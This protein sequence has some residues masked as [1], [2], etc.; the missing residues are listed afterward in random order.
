VEELDVEWEVYSRPEALKYALASLFRNNAIPDQMDSFYSASILGNCTE[1]LK[2][3][4]MESLSYEQESRS[5]PNPQNSSLVFVQV[6][7]VQTF[8]TAP[9]SATYLSTSAGMSDE[10]MIP[11]I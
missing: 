3:V 8:S 6:S 5:K 1:I 7:W 11:L 10:Y 2:L 4:V 9:F